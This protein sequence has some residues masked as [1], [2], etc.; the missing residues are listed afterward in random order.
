M[1]TT[2][3]KRAGFFRRAVYGSLVAGI[4][5]ACG[6]AAAS[7]LQVSPVSLQMDAS[8]K[9]EGLWLSNTGSSMVHAQVRIYRWTQNADGDRLD[10][11]DALLAS[12]PMLQIAPGGRQLIRVV[13][14]GHERE[15]NN[16]ETSYR[17][18]ID[19]LPIAAPG[20][21]LQ[22]VLS[23][24]VPIFIALPSK[25]VTPALQWR[26]DGSGAQA[27]LQVGNTGTG[28]AQVMDVS[29][30]GASGKRTEVTGGLLGYVL[31]GAT[32]HW[33]LKA[34]AEAFNEG[35]TLD[36]MV[37]GQKVQENLSLA[38]RAR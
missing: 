9:A 38:S 30:T 36:G 11:T 15:P 24:S 1:A 6:S 17:A 21:G 28:H 34:P 19:E 33:T 2:S 20:K 16:V 12:P 23:Y 26:V 25:P 29:F 32:M 31:P 37:N 14:V 8:Q 13:R 35:G 10:P 5:L 3:L 4:M 27:T 7:G 22:F 18:R